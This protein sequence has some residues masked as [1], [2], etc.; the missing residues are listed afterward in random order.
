MIEWWWYLGN[1]KTS[2]GRIFGV[3]MNVFRIDLQYNCWTMHDDV[4]THGIAVTQHVP[5]GEGHMFQ[6][7]GV[8]MGA[9]TKFSQGPFEPL[10]IDGPFYHVHQHPSNHNH[11]H[12]RANVRV[13]TN[14]TITTYGN[15][16]TGTV[17][18]TGPGD[19][20]AGSYGNTPDKDTVMMVL[21]FTMNDRYGPQTMAVN[22]FSTLT[23]AGGVV[24]PN[25]HVEQTWL[26]STGRIIIGNQSFDVEGVF[27]MSHQWY[28]HILHTTSSYTRSCTD[29]DMVDSCV[30]CVNRRDIGRPQRVVVI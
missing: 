30:M 8:T 21:D 11:Y 26:D 23:T 20:T 28:A 4:I 16:Y 12:L 3:Q 14:D 22:G 9:F 10:T 19:R 18:T 1:V 29:D 6:S 2:D 5:N 15:S 17:T 27:Y 7:N 24:Y 13:P 25:A